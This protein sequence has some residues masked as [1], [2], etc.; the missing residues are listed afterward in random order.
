VSTGSFSWGI[1]GFVVGI[2]LSI[3]GIISLAIFFPDPVAIGALTTIASTSLAALSATM[4]PNKKFTETEKELKAT[5]AELKQ[6]L[7]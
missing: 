2:I 7:Q 5:V 1:V 3:A 4:N 6:T